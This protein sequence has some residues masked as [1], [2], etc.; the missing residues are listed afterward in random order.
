MTFLI[1][2]NDLPRFASASLGRCENHPDQLWAQRM[3]N[4]AQLAIDEANAAAAMAA[5]RSS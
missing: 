3:L 5:S 4:G 1:P 2:T